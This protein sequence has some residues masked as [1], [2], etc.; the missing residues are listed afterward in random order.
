MLRWADK[1]STT[2]AYSYLYHSCGSSIPIQSRIIS[3]V[4]MTRGSD[5]Y[6]I[7]GSSQTDTHDFSLIDAGN[8][9]VAE[10]RMNLLVFLKNYSSPQTL[11]Y[12]QLPTMRR[13]EKSKPF[14][15]LSLGP[16]SNR[17]LTGAELCKYLLCM[18]QSHSGDT[19]INIWLVP[20]SQEGLGP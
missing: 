19:H 3:T 1:A 14:I 20:A 4:S 18:S 8:P 2:L 12:C 11:M 10:I 15:A 9:L 13:A 17:S 6:G 7:D 16:I 5:E